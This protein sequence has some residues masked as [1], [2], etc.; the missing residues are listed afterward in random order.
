MPRGKQEPI[1][2]EHPR[3][4]YRIAKKGNGK[5]SIRLSFFESCFPLLAMMVNLPRL[6]RSSPNFLRPTCSYTE[7]RSSSATGS[8]PYGGYTFRL[9]LLF[10]MNPSMGLLTGV[11]SAERLS[12]CDAGSTVQQACPMER[13]APAYGVPFS[14]E[15]CPKP[16][17]RIGHPAKFRRL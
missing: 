13:I 9:Q 1:G 11:A 5:P 14:P 3:I 6:M 17:D 2:A 15:P 10:V 16:G 7:C 4:E 8:L 12:G